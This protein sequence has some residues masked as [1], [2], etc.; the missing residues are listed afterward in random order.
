MAADAPGEAG[1]DAA[2]ASAEHRPAVVLL[3]DV[4]RQRLVALAADA[5]DHLDAEAMPATLRP[6]LSFARQRRARLAAAAL[7]GALE[8]DDFRTRVAAQVRPARAGLAG[9][10]ARGEPAAADPVEVAA[11]AFLLR[12]P[13]WVTLLAAA[14]ERIEAPGR[15]GADEAVGRLQSQLAEARGGLAALRATQREQV[16][17]LKAEN[18]QLRRRITDER[19][20]ARQ[21]RQVA[22]TVSAELD[23]S[24]QDAARQSAALQAEQRR[25]R[26]KV[27]DLGRELQTLR[28]VERGA[29]ADE[30]MRSRL[31]L[32]TLIDAAHGLRRELA[33]PPVEALPADT[34]VPA[35][36]PAPPVAVAARALST[37]DPAFLH[38][39]ISLPGA[40]LLVDGYNV[41]KLGWP[42]TPLEAQRR[43]L[44]QELAP[45]VA[46]NG[47]E[48]TVVFDGAELAHRPA[49]SSPRGVRLL[50]SPA[51]ITA[52][53]VL[54][55]LV[56]A[57]PPGR[58]LVV[59]S[60]DG[61]VA[62][63]ARRAG[64]RVVPSATLLQLLGA[65]G[66]R[67]VGG[68]V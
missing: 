2:A 8:D 47:T 45:V 53:D 3:P 67:T 64:A 12:P 62:A 28:Q 25:L 57:E 16:A 20:Q 6:V 50:F 58:P 21:A 42:S 11:L 10:L 34:V 63:G 51:G 7:A 38:Q 31:L 66:T 65:R 23:R 15:Q 1:I 22:E 49:V 59:V 36:E 17:A 44:L 43:R 26:S 40:H 35:H 30:A 14:L 33:L 52:D 4:V 32:D 56:R 24:E 54:I 5:L 60:S 19:T 18:A 37:S 41:T 61:E 48:V 55:D 39:L 13:D 27:A 29:R 68:T 9:A 46:R